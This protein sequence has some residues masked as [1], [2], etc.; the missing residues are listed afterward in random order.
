MNPQKKNVLKIAVSII[1]LLIVGI[2]T[3]YQLQQYR[4][5]SALRAFF[6]AGESSTPVSQ[7]N[8][9]NYGVDRKE[10]GKKS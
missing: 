9:F 6:N 2:I 10:S 7:K 5:R 1:L 3:G 8:F 4:E